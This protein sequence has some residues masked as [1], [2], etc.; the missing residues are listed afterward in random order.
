MSLQFGQT[1]YAGLTVEHSVG[2]AA[3][4]YAP[5]GDGKP[6]AIATVSAADTFTVDHDIA[7]DGDY[8]GWFA[9]LA[10]GESRIIVSTTAASNTVV[11]SPAF[12]SAPAADAQVLI[13]PITVATMAKPSADFN[14]TA[15]DGSGAEAGASQQVCAVTVWGRD[16]GG[17]WRRL[18]VIAAADVLSRKNIEINNVQGFALY[19]QLT[20]L[21]TWGSTASL[22]WKATTRRDGY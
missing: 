4:G 15:Y 5:P 14:V 9:Q 22:E 19:F 21:N 10:N 20:A 1:R 8:V 16:L 18:K 17:A 11:V 12:T 7:A 2:V 13:T 3:P 6:T